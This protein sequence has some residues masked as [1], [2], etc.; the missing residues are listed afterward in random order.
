[1]LDIQGDRDR[2]GQA[3]L[4]QGEKRKCRPEHIGQ[5][6]QA[7]RENTL[8]FMVECQHKVFHSTYIIAHLSDIIQHGNGWERLG[9][10]GIY[11]TRQKMP[12]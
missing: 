4:T 2:P 12:S 5:A 11:G 7:R 10:A 1:M 3:R 6:G 9:T 8:F